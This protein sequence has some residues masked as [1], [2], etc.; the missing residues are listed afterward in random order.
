MRLDFAIS[1]IAAALSF[2]CAAAS[3]TCPMK[4]GPTWR[5]LRSAHFVL[6]TDEDQDTARDRIGQ[7]E[8]SYGAFEDVFFD[9]EPKVDGRI[10]IVLF[11]SEESYRQ[12]SPPGSD[13]HFKRSLRGPDRM[14]TIVMHGELKG[15]AREIF[16]H[17]LTHRFMAFY[18]PSCPVWLN[19]GMAMLHETARLE[20]G[21]LVLGER[22]RDI[23]FSNAGRVPVPVP[24]GWLKPI[25][26]AEMPS[27]E[28]LLDLSH[29]SFYVRDIEDPD[30]TP[31]RRLR[32]IHYAAAEALVHVLYLG[33]DAVRTRFLQYQRILAAATEDPG[34]A[35]RAAFEELLENGTISESY[36]NYFQA[37]DIKVAYVPYEPPSASIEST[38]NMSHGETHAL[39]TTLYNWDN[40]AS[41]KKVAEE[42]DHAVQ[43]S[44]EDPEP[45]VMRGMLRAQVGDR[46]A[47]LLDF[48]LAA[49]AGAQDVRYLLPLAELYLASEAA[50][51]AE[52]RIWDDIEPLVAKIQPAA[53]EAAQ[54]DFLAR[55]ALLRKRFDVAL[56][57]AARAVTADASCI[58]CYQTA[59]FI[60]EQQGKLAEAI[61][62]QQLALRT[63]PEDSR[64]DES[65][66][67]LRALERSSAEHDRLRQH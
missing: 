31:S 2:G 13:A 45:L 40:D 59:S 26:I 62:A 48:K 53:R 42:L 4:G 27:V 44:P 3:F 35:F 47:A 18:F 36:T 46:E 14:P 20:N 56:Q 51:P 24:G 41:R 34:P 9:H 11:S 16:Q 54:H 39:W 10:R 25:P 33:D 43:A 67:R 61:K 5:E 50:I 38:R 52:Q 57:W 60:F 64:S 66:Q 8:A 15:G 12:V 63:M 1:C 17:E 30:S 37:V 6:Q 19:E 65:V 32:R 55:Y 28:G 7:F 58:A 29:A 23:L 22:R 49:Q 21:R